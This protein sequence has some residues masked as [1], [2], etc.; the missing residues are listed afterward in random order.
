MRRDQQVLVDPS[1]A[2]PKIAIICEGDGECEAMPTLAT[3]LLQ[4]LNAPEFVTLPPMR[5][6]GLHKVASPAEDG[7]FWRNKVRYAGQRAKA[8]LAVFDGDADNFRGEP[9]CEVTAAKWLASEACSVGAGAN[10][11]LAV[12]IAMQ[13]YETWLIG[14]VESLAGKPLSKGVSTVL[15]DTR[16]PPHPE[17]IRGAKEWLRKNMPRGYPYKPMTHQKAMTSAVDLDSIVAADLRSF[18]RLIG[19][20]QSLINGVRTGNHVCTPCPGP[21]ND[22]SL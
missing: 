1:N 2:T 22:G 14:G 3:R 9:F 18:T 4:R 20:M 16:C 6:G 21:L 8:V 7:T 13:E 15:A 5:L 12:V 10:F 19:A 17:G 11:S